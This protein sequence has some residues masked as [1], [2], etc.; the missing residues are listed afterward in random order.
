[1]SN[2]R[3]SDG[4][5]Q[6]SE[7]MRDDRAVGER[8]IPALDPEVQR[9]RRRRRRITGLV[10]TLVIV[11]LVGGYVGYT[12]TA[13][14]GAAAATTRVPGV[15][16]PAA[17]SLVMSP[18]GASAVTVTGG[19]GYLPPEAA[20]IWATSGGDEP[21]P[22]ASITKLITAFVILQAKP[23]S[24][25]DDAGPTITFDKDDHELYDK[26]YV[27][28]A[29]I[30]EMPTGSRMTEHDALETMLIAS[31][32][33]YAEAVAYWAFGSQSAFVAATQTWLAANGLTHTTIVEP[34]GIDAR[35]TS[36]PTDMIALA[37]LAMANPIIARIAAT[38][39]L[40]VPGIDPMSNTNN[41]LGSHG[42]T[43][44]KTGTLDDSGSNLLFTASLD[45]G[46]PEPLTVAGVVLGGFSRDTTSND[47]IGILESITAGFHEVVVA[48]AG[49][50]V[51]T[52]TTPWG[53]S[54]E[55]RLAD[56]ASLLT[57][58]DTPITA[59]MTTSTLDTG[60]DGDEV[61][62][63]TFTAGTNTVTVPV[64]LAGSIRPPSTSWRLT[65][66]F[67]LGG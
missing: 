48:E 54:A 55:M 65:H 1:M 41:L 32:S 19:D 28:G 36:T 63:V 15:V 51:G 37:R 10:V 46:L 16:P 64:E 24:G 6:L 34:T 9:R 40:S 2:H 38:Q 18:E 58:S 43:G 57:W 26:Y 31:A 5:A 59:E 62:S 66:P 33:N 25:V 53:E 47:V 20:G 30:A 61:G 60:A 8:D 14:V 52:Y 12:L 67:E 22:I 4:I 56:D 35:N 11:A 45:V 39:V 50:T 49:Q 42:I 44:L 29:T 21:R 13:P 23:L 17:A 7:L 3:D 27:L